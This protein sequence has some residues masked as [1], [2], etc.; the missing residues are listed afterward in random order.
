MDARPFPQQ[1]E[2]AVSLPDYT[3]TGQRE[4]IINVS[5]SSTQSKSGAEN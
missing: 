1:P 2:L 5:N 4:N 3:G